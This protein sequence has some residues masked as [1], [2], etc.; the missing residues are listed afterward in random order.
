M[1]LID[2]FP[3]DVMISGEISLESEITSNPVE[4]GG[5][6]TDHIRPLPVTLHF[7]SVVSDSPIG[8]IANHESR[9]VDDVT[10]EFGSALPSEDAYER[11]LDIRDFRRV[12]VV[13][14]PRGRGRKVFPNMALEEL[15]I[16]EDKETGGGLHFEATF[17][18]INFV[19]NR[20]VTVR[21]AT[22]AGKPKAQNKAAVGVS[23]RTDQTFTWKMGIVPGGTL[24][25]YIDDERPGSPWAVVEVEYADGKGAPGAKKRH[26]YSGEAS[27]NASARAKQAGTELTP[28]EVNA[29]YA[30]L[31]RDI[32]A[33]EAAQ[34]KKLKAELEAVDKQGGWKNLPKGVDLD[35]FQTPANFKPTVP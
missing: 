21:T 13:E 14:I 31:K 1:I 9:R 18:Q 24:I 32:N 33:K 3:Y 11:L 22:P 26:F 6:V 5:D 20:R 23:Y 7:E 2:G 8:E 4:A 34:E 12:V 15:V 28:A 29:L 35:R 30:D 27:N 17:K 19:T 16:R 10:E 25:P